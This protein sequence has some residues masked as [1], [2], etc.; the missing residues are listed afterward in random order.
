MNKDNTICF[1]TS[2]EIKSSLEK[3]AEKESK[4]VSSVVE[5]I[6]YHY[7][8]NDKTVE[9]IFQNRRRFERKK[10][11]IQAYIGDSRW[12]RHDFVEGIIL[13]ISFGGIQI[14]IPKGTKVESRN[15]SET[16]NFSIIFRVPNYHWPIHMKICTQ[17]VCETT[18]ELQ[19]GA[20]LMNPDFHA[21]SALQ[22]YLM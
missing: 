1:Q 19:I 17:R 13:D 15:D 10:V 11:S 6:I 5:S 8:I 21:Y 22:K 7:L 14:S 2:S 4:S 3:I 9:G 20:A 12:Q 16:D 18:E